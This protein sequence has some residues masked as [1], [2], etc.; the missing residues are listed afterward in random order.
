[1]QAR[2]L[3]I[4]F[5]AMFLA[6]GQCTTYRVLWQLSANTY[7]SLDLVCGDALQF[8]WPAGVPHGLAEIPSIVCPTVFT[9]PGI[10]VLK[11][12]VAGPANYTVSLSSPG[13]H[14]YTSPYL[15]PKQ[16]DCDAGM[17]IAITV[18]GACPSPPP[19]SPSPPPT[20]PPPAS[21][22][23]PPVAIAPAAAAGTPSAAPQGLAHSAL[24][25]VAAAAVTAVCL[26]M[27]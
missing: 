19:P 17:L 1:M 21:S 20:P 13:L 16:R 25:C 4:A 26:V 22:P 11:T 9:G 8:E 24:A 18:T 23:P 10:T 14:Y 3:I 5:A 12:P 15:A 2:W 6:G 27:A 7:P